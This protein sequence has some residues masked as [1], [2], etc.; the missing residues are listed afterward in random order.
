MTVTARGASLRTA[1]VRPE[2]SLR[3]RVYACVAVHYG[4]RKA[5]KDA[6]GTSKS[7]VFVQQHSEKCVCRFAG[8]SECTVRNGKASY[9]HDC[10]GEHVQFFN[11]HYHLL[12]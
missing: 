12:T 10:G 11:F 9:V 4:L 5:R 7:N 2:C 1:A 6:G 3:L 8:L